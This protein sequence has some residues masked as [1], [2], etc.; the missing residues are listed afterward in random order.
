MPL[1]LGPLLG[2]CQLGGIRLAERG[3]RTELHAGNHARVAPGA[4]RVEDL[5][6]HDVDVLGDAK[7]GPAD[8]SSDVAP[9]SVLVVVLF[10]E[11]VSE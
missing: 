11:Q 8:C 10:I 2:E 3:K 1:R 7:G 4:V 6:G 9:V 5:D